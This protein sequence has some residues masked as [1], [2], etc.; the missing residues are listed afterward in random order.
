MYKKT[1]YLL[2]SR[3][4]MDQH[5]TR[6]PFPKKNR[7]L[8]FEFLERDHHIKSRKSKNLKMPKSAIANSHYV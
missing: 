7:K 2:F 1:I 6:F 5:L 4:S 8:Y 3:A